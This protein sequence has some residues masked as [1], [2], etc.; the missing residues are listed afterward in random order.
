VLMLVNRNPE[1]FAA[2]LLL[3]PLLRQ[4]PGQR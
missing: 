3:L 1:C 2:V 4:A